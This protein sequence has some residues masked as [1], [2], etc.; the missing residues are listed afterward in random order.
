[1]FRCRGCN[2]VSAVADKSGCP[3][4]YCDGGHM[5][6][7]IPTKCVSCDGYGYWVCCPGCGERTCIAF[8]MDCWDAN[9]GHGPAGQ[10]VECP[11]CKGTGK[12][13]KDVVL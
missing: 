10:Q 2:A 7:K 4:G 11:D 6:E 1:M 12:V 5:W 3:D 9:G 8:S 13:V